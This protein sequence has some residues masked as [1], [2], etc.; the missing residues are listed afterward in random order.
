MLRFSFE[1]VLSFFLLQLSLLV[2]AVVVCPP[3]EAISPCTCS[4]YYYTTT[5]TTLNCAGQNLIDSQVSAIL[6]AY[7]KTPNVSPVGYLNLSFN[8]LTRVPVQVKSFTQLQYAFL[9]DNSISSIESGAFNAPDAYPL[10]NLWLDGNQ[11][12]TIAPGAF[13]GSNLINFFSTAFQ[14]LLEIRILNCH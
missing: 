14:F 13:K 11:L 10:S 6:D 4:E 9:Y 7:L 8:L 5:T 3:V 12:T 2:D 1:F